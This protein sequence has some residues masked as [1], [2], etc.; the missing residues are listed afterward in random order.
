MS[1]SSPRACSEQ[2]APGMNGVIEQVRVGLHVVWRRRWLAIAV[3]WGIALVGWLAVSRIPNVFESHA[4][5]YVQP[6][7]ILP[8]AVGITSNDQ[9]QDIDDVR[10]NLLSSDT[11]QSVVKQ[12]VLA[13]NATTPRDMAN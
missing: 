7:S 10:Q 6:Q 9:Q 8:Q 13:R 12:T 5:V 1:S 11:L 2:A 4:K 3:A